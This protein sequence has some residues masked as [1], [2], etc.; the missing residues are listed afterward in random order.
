MGFIKADRERWQVVRG[1]RRAMSRVWRIRRFRTATV[2]ALVSLELVVGAQASGPSPNALVLLDTGDLF[3]ARKIAER[4]KDLD[5]SVRL[6]FPP[7]ALIVHIPGSVRSQVLAG[8]ADLK[9]GRV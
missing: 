8:A 5:V 7:S 9:L 1:R 3:T 6:F 4:L 2:A